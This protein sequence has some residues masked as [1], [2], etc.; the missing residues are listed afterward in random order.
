LAPQTRECHGPPPVRSVQGLPVR[1]TALHR[2]IIQFSPEPNR[3]EDRHERHSKGCS[4]RPGVREADGDNAVRRRKDD[5]YCGGE[6]RHGGQE[7]RRNPRS[8]ELSDGS[9]TGYGGHENTPSNPRRPR[10][11]NTVR[12]VEAGERIDVWK[13]EP[14]PGQKEQ[15]NAEEAQ[16][17]QGSAAPRR[18][19]RAQRLVLGRKRNAVLPELGE[20]VRRRR[21]RLERFEGDPAHGAAL[22]LGFF[23]HLAAKRTGHDRHGDS[24]ILHHPS[25]DSQGRPGFRLFFGRDHGKLAA[26][27]RPT[28]LDH[29]IDAWLATH[30]GWAREGTHAITREFKFE[31]FASALAF[32]VRLGCLAEKRDHHPDVELGWGRVKVLWTTHDAGGLTKLDLELAEATAKLAT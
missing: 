16:R 15:A 22:C 1:T 7:T 4:Y 18:I 8:T 9:A 32:V 28:K 20:D 31:D 2:D 5:E 26:M 24:R 29:G 12:D 23:E 30:D 25:Y 10:P 17:D 21:K 11:P 14:N 3:K 19:G 27:T 13:G 6:T